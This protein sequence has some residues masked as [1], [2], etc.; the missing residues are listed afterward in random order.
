[1]AGDALGFRWERLTQEDYED[2]GLL[3]RLTTKARFAA[4]RRGAVHGLQ[5]ALNHCNV[6]TGQRILDLLGQVARR[7]ESKRVREYALWTLERGGCWNQKKSNS[8]L[9]HHARRTVRSI[10][11][12]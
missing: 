12:A 6:R 2:F 3:C 4:G 5:H 10:D 1:M 8:T 9:R 7:D 11:Q